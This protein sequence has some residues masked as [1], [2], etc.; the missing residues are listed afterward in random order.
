MADRR[1]IPDPDR[2]P[3]LIALLAA[4]TENPADLGARLRLGWALLGAGEL[5]GARETFEGA[6]RDFPRDL[7]VLY[8]LA[9]S[10]KKL[11][12]IEQASAAFLEV[13]RL[14]ETLPDPGRSAILHRLAVGHHNHARSG[15]WGL[16][17]EVW[18]VD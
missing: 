11:G 5:A 17:R 10:A 4:A 8:G 1:P 9:L 2:S 12:A 14:A 18:G 7:D 15:R 6:Q 3:D 16:K 13:A